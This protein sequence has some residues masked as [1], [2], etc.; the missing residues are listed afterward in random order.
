[1]AI[2]K[3]I[4]IIS[5]SK[6]GFEDAIKAGISRA[7]ETVNDISGAWVQDQKVIVE[8]GKVV[9]YRVVMKVTFVLKAG[10]RSAKK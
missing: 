1:M 7:S 8:K 6:H 10:K 9:E 3:V 4:E 5:S 2:A